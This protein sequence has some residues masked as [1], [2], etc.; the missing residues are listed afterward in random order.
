MIARPPFEAGAFQ[1]TRAEPSAGLADTPVGAPGT[2]AGMTA[3]EAAEA[4]PVPAEF[5]ALTLNV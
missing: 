3:F 2:V 1:L 4:G 5:V